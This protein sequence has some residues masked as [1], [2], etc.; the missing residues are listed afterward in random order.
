MGHLT[1]EVDR[2]DKSLNSLIPDNPNKPYD[3]HELIE[4]I[5][6]NGDFFELKPDYAGNILTGFGRMGGSP[7]WDCCQSA[8]DPRRVS[9]YS[10]LYQS[11]PLH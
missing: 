11:G 4:K 8:D 1:D 7:D 3:M 2:E 9:R 10:I 5:V 6:D